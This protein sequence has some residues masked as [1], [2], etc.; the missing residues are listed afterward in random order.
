MHDIINFIHDNIIGF[1]TNTNID[2]IIITTNFMF[3]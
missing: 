1:Y 2:T 3:R